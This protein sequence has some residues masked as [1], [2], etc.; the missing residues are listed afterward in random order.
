M[1]IDSMKTMRKQHLLLPALLAL[2]LTMGTTSCSD[3]DKEPTEEQKEQQAIEQTT[4]T[5]KF[6]AVVSQLAGTDSFTEDWQNKI[7]DPIIGQATGGIESVRTIVTGDLKTAA[8]RFC[9][10][11]G[12][13]A[14]TFNADKDYTWTDEN[15]GTLTFKKTGGASLAT[16]DV[17]IKQMPGLAQLVYKTPEQV[18]ANGTFTGTAYYRF[19]DIVAKNEDGKT[20][21]WICVRPAF[22]TVEGKEDSH[23]V[24]ISPVHGKYVKEFN[25][26]GQHHYLP[27]N[28]CTNKEHLENFAEMMYAMLFPMYYDEN[29]EADYKTLG[30][31]HDFHYEKTYEL[32]GSGFFEDVASYWD[33]NEL[34]RLIFGCSRTF[35]S[36]DTETNGFNL[37]YGNGSTDGDGDAFTQQM[38]FYG[39]NFRTSEK[40][41]LQ[42]NVDGGD[43]D[44]RTAVNTGAPYI[45]MRFQRPDMRAREGRFYVVRYKTG[46]ELCK[47]S[48]EAASYDKRKRLTNCTDVYVYNRNVAHLNMDDLRSVE[49]QKNGLVVRGHYCIGDVYEDE[50]HDRWLVVNM[51]GH[52]MERS[53]Y[54]EL[55][56][57]E[58]IETRPDGARAYDLPTRDQAIR[59]TSFLWNL[60]MATAI[61]SSPEDMKA[62]PMLPSSAYNMLMAGGVDMRRLFVQTLASKGQQRQDTEQACIAF[63]SGEYDDNG[64]QRLLRFYCNHENEKQDPHLCFWE[65]YPATPSATE[66][67]PT[68]FSNSVIRLQ[69]IANADMVKAHAEDHYARRPLQMYSGGDGVSV[70]EPRSEIDTR[71]NDVYNYFYNRVVWDQF[72]Y[73]RDMWNAPVIVMRYAAVYDRGEKHYSTTTADG[74]HTLSL[75]Q[76]RPLNNDEGVDMQFQL[77]HTL[78]PGIKSWET[79]RVD[80]KEQPLPHWSETVLPY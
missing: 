28:L 23:W 25:K 1:T 75:V 67:F 46:K 59:A 66:Q 12:I 13:D 14:S 43:Y 57:F 79:V 51:A 7:F 44:I 80:G 77:Y 33:N 52:H 10:L 34:F 45:T 4:K 36:S 48:D 76:A 38:C 29:L 69:D 39:K 37:I 60:Y 8:E 2:G 61:I 68:R 56:S 58:G 72:Q 54:A 49:P 24:S 18:G 78:N 65:H 17:D 64:C 22:G 9:N 30:Y 11:V 47:G 35:L 19:G 50:N 26:N 53:Q 42:V 31:F 3:D 32:N 73:P 70:R 63:D 20:D 74:K 40:M 16:V 71:A 55:V 5:N 6:W 21:Y 15:V 62:A 27:V 41:E